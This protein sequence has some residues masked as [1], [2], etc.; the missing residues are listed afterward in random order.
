MSGGWG[1]WSFEKDLL[2][3]AVLL[4]GR[5]NEEEETSD[6]SV[7]KQPRSSR[8]RAEI[9]GG[10]TEPLY[11]TANMDVQELESKAERIAR[12]KAER[13]RQLA[14][15]Y[16]L[17]LDSDLDS[18][19]S[20]R[21]TRARKDP[22]SVERKAVKS[23]R[24]DNENKD[25][26]TLYLSRTETKASKSVISDSKEYSSHEDK[27]DLSNEKSV[28]K[29]DDSAIRQASDPSATLDSSVSLSL[30]GRDSSCY[31]EVPI[32]PKQTPRESLL[33][34]KRAASPTHLQNDQPLHSNSRQ[35]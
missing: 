14:E 34:P 12:Y 16:G 18:D 4:T 17:S 13:R 3:Y 26:G 1:T 8:Y 35:R 22:D 25:Y 32:S 5:S 7:E 31:N 27:D 33:S 15:K 6:S 28:R 30:S 11:S 29:A 9:T 20:S 23:E 21:Y 2:I 10:N 24:Q 19:Y